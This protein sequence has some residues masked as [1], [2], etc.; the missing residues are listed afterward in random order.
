[1]LVIIHEFGHFYFAK[2]AGILVREFAIG[3]GPKILSYRKNGTTYTV[4]LLPLGGYVRM[5]GYGDDEAELRAGMP[6]KIVLDQ[7]DQVTHIN[8]SEKEQIQSLPM[9]LT[10]FDLDKELF[11]EGMIPGKNMPIRYSVKRDALI[12]EPDGTEVQVAPIEVQFQSASLWNRILTNFAGPMNNF[13]LGII[14]FSLLAFMQGGVASNDNV[15]GDIQP[16]SPAE[17]AGLTQ[18]DR[19]V[20][21]DDQEVGTWQEMVVLIQQH[22]NEEIALTVEAPEGGDTKE[23]S[24]TPNEATTEQGESYGQ[25]GVYQPFDQ[26]FQAKVTF[27]FTQT[28]FI[29]TSIFSLI[30]SMFTRGFDIN[31]FGGPVAIYA[32][33]EEVVSYGFMSVLSFLGSLSVNLGTVNLLPIPA[34]DGGKILLNFV[35]GVRGKPLEPEKEGIITVIGVGLLFVLM[36]LITWND[37]QRFFFG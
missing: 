1:M 14:V 20:A 28:W 4:R 27:G 8:L 33:T 11:V 16:G 9:E 31:A 30:G 6:I 17:E 19:V 2:R 36:I 23:I 10:Q 35:E 12:I 37:I 18:G 5:A 25:I 29:I 34:L 13:I 7:D 15:L 26:S 24:I 3:M 21:I 22:P 32:A